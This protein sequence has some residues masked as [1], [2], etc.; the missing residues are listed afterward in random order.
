[1]WR[2]TTFLL[3]GLSIIPLCQAQDLASWMLVSSQAPKTQNSSE[4]S[5]HNGTTQDTQ[6][7]AVNSCNVDKIEFDPLVHKPSYTVAVHA[8]AGLEA[9]LAQSNTLFGEYLTK[10]AGKKF[11]PPIEFNVEAHLY[12]DLFNAIDNGEIDFFYGNSGIY[13]CIGTEVGAAAL[14]TVVKS[15]DIRGQ[16]YDLDVYLVE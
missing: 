8:I 6:D 4:T 5:L 7:I 13:S 15:Y 12:G 14:G 3:A 1:M 11:N 2:T 10:T 9:A 16:R